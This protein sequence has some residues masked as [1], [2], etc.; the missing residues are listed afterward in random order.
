MLPTKGG[1]N[2]GMF[3]SNPQVRPNVSHLPGS[4][5]VPTSLYF[6]VFSA[7]DFQDPSF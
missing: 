7:V 4:R 6:H 5:G 2:N 1:L 3:P